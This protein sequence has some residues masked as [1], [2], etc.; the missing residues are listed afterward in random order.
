MVV[1]RALTAKRLKLET[2]IAMYSIYIYIYIY[3]VY[4]IYRIYIYCIYIYIY[5]V[6]IIDMTVSPSLAWLRRP[7]HYPPDQ[8]KPVSMQPVATLEQP[9]GR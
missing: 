7:S 5:V 9:D 4:I 3:I 2:C 1:P 6:Y 8:A